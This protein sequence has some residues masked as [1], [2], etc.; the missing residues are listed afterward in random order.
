MLWKFC[1]CLQVNEGLSRH[2]MM[3]LIYNTFLNFMMSLDTKGLM[4][5]DILFMNEELARY[6]QTD[7]VSRTFMM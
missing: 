3:T 6:L 7:I 2:L 4:Y 5:L 1:V